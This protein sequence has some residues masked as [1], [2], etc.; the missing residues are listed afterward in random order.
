MKFEVGDVLVDIGRDQEEPLMGA[1]V[2]S[3][4]EELK[5]Y[6][7][8]LANGEVQ[9][10]TQESAEWNYRKAPTGT[11]AWLIHELSKFDPL[12]TVYYTDGWDWGKITDVEERYEGGVSVC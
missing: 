3:I 8:Q 10:E 1:V 4:S 9:Y 7:I 11:V 6:T 5:A 12:D 2:L